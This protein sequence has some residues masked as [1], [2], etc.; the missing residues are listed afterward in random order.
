MQLIKLLFILTLL[1]IPFNSAKAISRNFNSDDL[2]AK[3]IVSSSDNNLKLLIDQDQYESLKVHIY[4]SNDYYKY[5]FISPEINDESKF[6]IAFVADLNETK[7]IYEWNTSLKTWISVPVIYDYDNN[8]IKAILSNR[9]GK[10][11]LLDV[12]KLESTGQNIVFNDGQ[13]ELILPKVIDGTKVTTNILITNELIENS[14]KR[15]SPIYN[16]E[17]SSDINISETLSDSNVPFICEPY[18]ENYIDEVKKDFNDVVKLQKFLIDYENHK[19]IADGEFDSYTIKAI[20]SFQLKYASQ[21]LD[22]WDLTEGTGNVYR[23][24]IKK[25]NEIYCDSEKTKS[26]FIELKLS[27]ISDNNFAKSVYYLDNN[28]WH[29][30]QSVDNHETNIVTGETNLTELT[31][32]L[33]ES[34]DT[35][36]G[37]ASWYAWKGGNFA[38][39]RDFPKGSK[40]KVTNQSD[41][42]NR[43]KSVIITV[44]DYGPEL[45]TKRIIDLDKVAYGL[46]GNVRGGVMPVKIE[47]IEQE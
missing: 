39:S 15:V 10:V 25:I 28:E 6:N 23:T 47:L 5:Y 11:K 33:F 9:K 4:K 31:I 34:T 8:L 29:Y 42:S 16:I 27:Y 18:L 32:A 35:W 7:Q 13:F 22:P 40:I 46:I 3:Q 17:L 36:V 2:N 20:N 41:S 24:T 44:N 19:L 12:E 45:W 14:L 26:S 37:E 30:L 43:G 38:A 21:I 1:I